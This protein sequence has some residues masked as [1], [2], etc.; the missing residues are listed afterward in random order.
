MN[1]VATAAWALA[2]VT[3]TA[4]HK[5]P[6]IPGGVIPGLDSAPGIHLQIRT[7]FA[8]LALLPS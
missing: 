1:E 8:S 7:V 2:K 3:M 6:V 5:H 4:S